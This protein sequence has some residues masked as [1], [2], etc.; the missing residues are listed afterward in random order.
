MKKINVSLVI[1]VIVL[2]LFISIFLFKDH[3]IAEEKPFS[4][5]EQFPAQ[6]H[7]VKVD[8][9]P[10]KNNYNNDFS[11]L[12]LQVEDLRRQVDL[13][14]KKMRESDQR[15]KA[16]ESEKNPDEIPGELSAAEIPADE[17]VYSQYEEQKVNLTA[18]LMQ[19]PVDK[20]WAEETINALEDAVETN[21]ELAGMELMQATCG[22]TLCKL[23]IN[24]G[25]NR[26][27]EEIMQKLSIH[28]TWKGPTTFAV[29]NSGHAEIIFARDGHSLE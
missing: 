23:E 19:E 24:I 3:K 28:R 7:T 12:D 10:E 6:A 21:E 16:M 17:A 11:D 5:E 27:A 22:S 1:P 2:A 8:S 4:G 18:R 29:N 25:Q 14:S 13:L 26:P 20:Q 9:S 15:A